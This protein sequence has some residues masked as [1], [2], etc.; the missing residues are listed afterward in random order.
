MLFHSY[1][2]VFL[3]F[4]LCIAGFYCCKAITV[5]WGKEW[6]LKLFLIL[7]SLWFYG[8]LQP[9]NLPVLLVSM[10]VN[11]GL[12][13]LMEKKEQKKFLLVT[14]LFLN[15]AALFFFKYTG[16]S[17]VPLGIS[18]FTFSQIAVLMEAYRGN[19]KEM[20]AADYGVYITFFPKLIQ[21]PIALPEE[22]L[23]GL[24]RSCKQKLQWDMV[25]RGSVLFVLG[26][27]KKVILADTLGGAVD[28]GYAGL[29]SLHSLDA[30]IVM[31]SYTLQIYF[32]FSGYCDMAMGISEILGFSLP[33]NFNAPY[34]AENIIDFW[35]GW[36]ITLTRFFTKYLYIPL[37]GNRKGEGRMYL[38]TLIVFF[39]SGIWHG[40]GLQFIVWG[41]MHG[42]L[43]VITRRLQK[44][45]EEKKSTGIKKAVSTFLTFLYVNLAWV[46]FRA[47]SVKEALTLLG[48]ILRFQW[49]RADYSLADYFNRDEFW[50][51][52]KV[53]HIDGWQYAHYIL[54]VLM[55]AFALIL[56]FAGKP[57][58][59]LAEKVKPRV[60]TSVLLAVLFVWC[61]LS[62]SQVSSFIY[63]NF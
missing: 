61:V 6:L 19:L 10:A 50:Y 18:F 8:F 2:F 39:I 41:L 9:A 56:V 17:F 44:G 60:L 3:F 57:A 29:S 20:K 45:K 40:A 22:F 42:V 7:M 28:Y 53:L 12:Y 38:N 51:V 23:T 35:K 24:S 63:F 1:A 48:T 13:C 27:A 55:L 59:V 34:Q 11:Y 25:Y 54:M 30:V 4:P 33:L 58:A 26:M 52:I 43:Y 36:H 31:L 62:F 46:F 14:G 5:K 32:D 49:V 21:G 16:S 37:G 47:S 15:L